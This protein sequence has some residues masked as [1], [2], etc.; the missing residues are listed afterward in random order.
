[1][2]GYVVYD[3]WAVPRISGRTEIRNALT[4]DLPTGSWHRVEQGIDTAVGKVKLGGTDYSMDYDIGG[5]AGNYATYEVHQPFVWQKQDVKN[6]VRMDYS[7]RD[8]DGRKTLFVSFPELGPANFWTDLRDS[9]D[10]E[11]ILEIMRTVRPIARR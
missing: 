5:L 10:I 8:K 1:M 3:Y 4:I 9:S 11:A 7:L 6:G 2:L